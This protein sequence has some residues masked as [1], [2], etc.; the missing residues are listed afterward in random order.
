M[1]NKSYNKMQMN[2]TTN[3]FKMGQTSVESDKNGIAVA[4][5]REKHVGKL[6]PLNNIVKTPKIEGK[7]AGNVILK[8][9]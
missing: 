5:Q 8:E 9:A 3:S 2:M 1:R 7:N 6:Q 4:S